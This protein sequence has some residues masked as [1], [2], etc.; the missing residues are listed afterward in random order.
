MNPRL[1]T[2]YIKKFTTFLAIKSQ[3]RL[4]YFML[5]KKLKPFPYDPAI[6]FKV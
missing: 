6:T 1:Y 3:Y 4:S 2:L 5:N